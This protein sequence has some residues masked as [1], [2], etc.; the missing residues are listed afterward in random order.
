VKQIFASNRVISRFE[1]H[2]QQHQ[3]ETDHR[4]SFLRTPDFLDGQKLTKIKNWFLLS[5]A[6]ALSLASPYN[7]FTRNFEFMPFVDEHYFV[8]IAQ[9][10]GIPFDHSP[11]MYDI[12][13]KTPTERPNYLKNVTSGI[14][15]ASGHLF[16]RKVTN[17]TNISLNW[18]DSL[19]QSMKLDGREAGEL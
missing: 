8:T 13:P 6:A 5:E 10:I 3:H 18:L 7:D 2:L 17:E 9:K 15:H 1:L 14:F 4:A 19:E 11:L 12:W 16:A